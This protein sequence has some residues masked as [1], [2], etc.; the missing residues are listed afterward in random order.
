MADNTLFENQNPMNETS[1][2]NLLTAMEQ[3]VLMSEDSELND[4]FYKEA[5]P[6]ISYVEQHTG[7]S[8]IQAIL[9]SV[10]TNL[11]DRPVIM[12]RDV[13]HWL[14][15]PL[16]TLMKYLP[17]FD[18][19]VE[20]RLIL[21]HYERMVRRSG[22]RIPYCVIEQLK[23]NRLT[24]HAEQG[25]MDIHRLFTTIELIFARS[26]DGMTT[27]E[28]RDTIVELLL[29][30]YKTT[31]SHTGYIKEMLRLKEQLSDRDF[32]LLNYFCHLAMNYHCTEVSTVKFHDVLGSHSED[33]EAILSFTS[34]ENALVQRGYIEVAPS[35]YS[36]P[37]AMFSLTET[38]KSQLL[39]F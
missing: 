7:L 4:Q 10:M 12:L 9:L 22:Y 36:K 34:G 39:P 26:A 21:P 31:G 2:M 28:R 8:P 29:K 24:P 15:M 38:A 16:I 14:D 19:L 35:P 3:I 27:K 30:L 17:D 33:T 20:R 1:A 32:V 6:Y 37:S 13:Q 11:S 18:V 25:D 5:A 23:N